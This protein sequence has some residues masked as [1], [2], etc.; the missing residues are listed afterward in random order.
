MLDSINLCISIQLNRVH[1][2]KLGITYKGFENGIKFTYKNVKFVYYIPFKNLSIETTTHKILEKIDITL[3]DKKIYEEELNN[4]I[5]EIV[6][7]KGIDYVKTAFLTRVDYYID[8][9]LDEEKL[10]TYLKLSY[11][12]CYDPAHPK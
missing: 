2:R 9:T 10:N 7:S 4:I 3:S 12:F 5:N 6:N 8:I 11:I 1:L